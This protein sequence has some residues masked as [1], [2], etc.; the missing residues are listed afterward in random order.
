MCRFVNINQVIG[1]EGWV[2]RL[3]ATIVFEMA[4]SVLC[5]ALNP[6]HRFCTELSEELCW[7]Y[8]SCIRDD[9][10]DDDAVYL[11]YKVPILSVCLLKGQNQ[12]PVS[13]SFHYF[14]V[15]W[16]PIIDMSR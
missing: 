7:I 2:Q 10:F 4:R 16:C 13:F 6:T 1:R 5:E 3:A 12:N 15:S 14:H 9:K 11:P 8:L